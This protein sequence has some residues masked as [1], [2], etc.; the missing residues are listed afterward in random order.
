MTI[1][2]HEEKCCTT[3]VVTETGMPIVLEFISD[4]HATHYIFQTVGLV[5]SRHWTKIYTV[6]IDVDFSWALIHSILREFNNIYDKLNDMTF[7]VGGVL[8]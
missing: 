4:Q 1:F 5:Q 7:T 8:L 6:R 2:L 3:M